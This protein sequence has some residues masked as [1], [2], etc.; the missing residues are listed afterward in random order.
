MT[1]LPAI[2]Y[3]VVLTA[4]GAGILYL[5]YLACLK[6]VDWREENDRAKV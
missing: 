5:A 4:V 3:A 2:V 6:V 1:G